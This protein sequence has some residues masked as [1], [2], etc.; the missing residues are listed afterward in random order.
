MT[1]PAL[2]PAEGVTLSG[3]YDLLITFLLV[4]ARIMAFL[5]IAPPFN[6]RGVPMRAS[7]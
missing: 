5:V 2:A 7:G 3:S 1:V 4:M 6:G